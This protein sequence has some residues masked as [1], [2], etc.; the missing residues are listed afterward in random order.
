M[1]V[2]RARLIDV[3]GEQLQPRRPARAGKL[4]LRPTVVKDGSVQLRRRNAA[5]ERLRQHGSGTAI[6]QGE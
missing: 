6:G 4:G 1:A 5:R 2:L 3:A